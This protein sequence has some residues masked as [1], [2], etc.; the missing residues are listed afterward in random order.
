MK[1]YG[2]IGCILFIIVVT[3]ILPVKAQTAETKDVIAIPKAKKEKY[4]Q[5]G[6]HLAHKQLMD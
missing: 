5:K 4:V 3:S 1:K 6:K 2:S